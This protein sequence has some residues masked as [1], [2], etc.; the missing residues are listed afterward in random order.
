MKPKKLSN[1]FRNSEHGEKAE[2]LVKGGQ[3]IKMKGLLEE[4]ESY[5]LQS[6]HLFKLDGAE[7]EKP[8]PPFRA[9][10]VIVDKIQ[11]DK[12]AAEWF[13]ERP[14]FGADPDNT[15]IPEWYQELMSLLGPWM[16]GGGHMMFFRANVTYDDGIHDSS[17][18][19][20][21]MSENWRIQ[22]EARE[23]IIQQL[24][25]FD[26]DGVSIGMDSEVQD[27]IYNYL[28][29]QNEANSWITPDMITPWNLHGL[30]HYYSQTNPGYNGDEQFRWLGPDGQEVLNSSGGVMG[31]TGWIH[32]WINNGPGAEYA[33]AN[34]WQWPSSIDP[35][36]LWQALAEGAPMP[37]DP[38]AAMYSGSQFLVQL[39]TYQDA[40]SNPEEFPE[41][42]FDVDYQAAGYD[43]LYEYYLGTSTLF[44]QN[45]I[46]LYYQYFAG[47]G[48]GYEDHAGSAFFYP[49]YLQQLFD[50]LGV[51]LDTS[52][53]EGY[54]DYSGNIDNFFSGP[55]ME[56]Y[57]ALLDLMAEYHSL[58]SANQDDGMASMLQAYM[59]SNGEYGWNAQL[60]DF[61][62]WYATGV[63]AGFIELSEAGYDAF[64]AAYTAYTGDPDN[65]F[66]WFWFDFSE[67]IG[68][69]NFLNI[70][71]YTLTESGNSPDWGQTFDGAS[72]N[73]GGGYGMSYYDFDPQADINYIS[74][75]AGYIENFPMPGIFGSEGGVPEW[76]TYLTHRMADW[77]QEYSMWDTTS[78]FP[79]GTLHNHYN[80]Y[81]DLLGHTLGVIFN[82]DG[83]NYTTGTEMQDLADMGY[84]VG[85]VII[86]W[87]DNLLP[88]GVTT[89]LTIDDLTPELFQI[90][91]QSEYSYNFYNL[92][93]AVPAFEENG[94]TNLGSS[95]LTGWLTNWGSYSTVDEF[96]TGPNIFGS[97]WHADFFNGS[98]YAMANGGNGMPAALD[99]LGI[100]E[101]NTFGGGSASGWGIGG[102]ETGHMGY[103]ANSGALAMFMYWGNQGMDD[104]NDGELYSG[105]SMFEN[106]EGWALP[107]G[108]GYAFLNSINYLTGYYSSNGV[109]GAGYYGTE[110]NPSIWTPLYDYIYETTGIEGV[111]MFNINVGTAEN[112]V[113]EWVPEAMEV[114]EYYTNNPDLVEQYQPEDPFSWEMLSSF[115][116]IINQYLVTAP[117]NPLMPGA[118]FMQD[119]IDMMDWYL[120]G[121]VGLGSEDNPDTWN[122]PLLSEMSDVAIQNVVT[123]IESGSF[124]FDFTYDITDDNF[125]YSSNQNTEQFYGDGFNHLT[126]GVGS[127]D[128]VLTIGVNPSLGMGGLIGDEANMD[129][130]AFIQAHGGMID[131]NGDGRVDVGD[132]L[133]L[134]SFYMSPQTV[135]AGL[136]LDASGFAQGQFNPFQTDAL[137]Y[138]FVNSAA[139]SEVSPNGSMNW[140]LMQGD[141]GYLDQPVDIFGSAFAGTQGFYTS[142]TSILSSF[143]VFQFVN[144]FVDNGAAPE[145]YSSIVN[146]ELSSATST[147]N[148]FLNVVYPEWTVWSSENY[149]VTFEDSDEYST[150]YEGLV[151]LL[152]APEVLINYATYYVGQGIDINQQFVVSDGN[153]ININSGGNSLAG[154]LWEDLSSFSSQQYTVNLVSNNAQFFSGFDLN[155]DGDYGFEDN[156]AVTLIVALLME[157]MYSLGANVSSFNEGLNISEILFELAENHASFS[158]LSASPII[159]D[160]L[161]V[162]NNYYG[163][164]GGPQ[165]QTGYFGNSTNTREALNYLLDV[166]GFDG[167]ISS[168]P[169]APSSATPEQVVEILSGMFT[170]V[171]A[172]LFAG[173]GLETPE[174]SPGF[175]DLGAL[176]DSYNGVLIQTLGQSFTTYIENGDNNAVLQTLFE[177]TD[178]SYYVDAD[179]NEI[180]FSFTAAGLQALASQGSSFLGGFGSGGPNEGLLSNI[181][182]SI[183]LLTEE[184]LSID[185][186]GDGVYD[187][188]DINILLNIAENGGSTP[189]ENMI[190]ELLNVSTHPDT[191]DFDAIDI[192]FLV[193]YLGLPGDQAL[194]LPGQGVFGPTT[195]NP[196]TSYNMFGYFNDDG[197]WVDFDYDDL[198]PDDYFGPGWSATQT[199]NNETTS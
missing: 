141:T 74:D 56:E 63:E 34:N 45:P 98:A 157:Y 36:G 193:Q 81:Y 148:D 44:A 167:F 130:V 52:I 150:I 159:T 55:G 42:D 28:I 142:F 190:A 20:G 136:A 155:Q 7:L 82:Y 12:A 154:G 26:Q 144:D 101:Y 66:N 160:I 152:P 69:D 172:S 80:F 50:T 188:N 132:I 110:E 71:E 22:R 131:Y 133:G 70:Y 68:S 87:W 16:A 145:W 107:F 10:K 84:P 25:D 120:Q 135:G 170:S 195:T 187:M 15:P 94:I 127:W 138:F 111:N 147:F 109:T 123:A 3:E 27:Y 6:S 97:T 51:N 177:N 198:T 40:T 59:S 33:L 196:F 161:S 114:N 49:Q 43:S 91:W 140:M 24:F 143:I 125:L 124:W 137:T 191:L 169:D 178:G 92:L 166:A 89:G 112:P 103:A 76:Y 96:G 57:Q 185:F 183:A 21:F 61:M 54:S 11:K 119:Q 72:Y 23:F 5:Y 32:D 14:G 105:T 19:A 30:G 99:P 158:V 48:Q 117:G 2:P 197:T 176:G 90:T 75:S 113:Y 171:I 126:G 35:F 156:T 163:P 39:V 182:E 31:P 118:N 67:E 192:L 194:E 102:N 4:Q 64:E 18:Y 38:L 41:I 58:S 100:W 168:D 199:N 106:G 29:D 47:G 186:N 37:D 184:G 146:G 181:E 175:L 9:S 174:T 128:E 93:E 86:D 73:E 134:I 85:Q 83:D 79:E 179:G 95:G 116:S 139:Y 149:N 8:E 60:A 46:M 104:D 189:E 88:E 165:G 13:E 129:I 77:N 1:T 122:G 108:G 121:V 62:D 151:A 17:D 173:G 164:G 162:L 153:T 115:F 65:P 78:T 53:T 180:P